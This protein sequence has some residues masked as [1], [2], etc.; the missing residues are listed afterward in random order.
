MGHVRPGKEGTD[1]TV[2]AVLTHLTGIVA[3][4]GSGAVADVAGYTAMFGLQTAIALASLA[5]VSLA[6]KT[7][8][9]HD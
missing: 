8:T 3:A 1:F 5:Y 9:T 2:Q 6:L 7:E 4:M